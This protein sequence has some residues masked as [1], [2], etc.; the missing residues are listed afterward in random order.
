MNIPTRQ[1]D[2]CLEKP[3]ISVKYKES[4]EYKTAYAKTEVA[5]I[6]LI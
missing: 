4:D 5:V 2:C 1:F 6:K 3:A